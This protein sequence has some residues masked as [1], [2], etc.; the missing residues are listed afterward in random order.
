[1]LATLI[2]ASSLTTSVVIAAEMA[3]A[4]STV[5]IA[6]LCA[7]LRPNS[8]TR[9]AW[10]A[11]YEFLWARTGSLMARKTVLAA[12]RLPVTDT[13]RAVRLSYQGG[14]VRFEPFEPVPPLP[15]GGMLIDCGGDVRIND[16]AIGVNL[17]IDSGFG[18]PGTGTS[19]AQAH[20]HRQFLWRPVV[21]YYA[22]Y[23]AISQSEYDPPAFKLQPRLTLDTSGGEF[24]VLLTAANQLVQLDASE[25]E[26][27]LAQGGFRSDDVPEEATSDG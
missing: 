10:Q 24:G 27:L 8:Y 16:V 25:V 19:V 7:V 14:L 22:Y 26:R 6:W 20:P 11:S 5:P 4:P 2:N 18:Q 12:E 3:E 21:E 13:V 15:E 1:M 9:F 17:R 23:G